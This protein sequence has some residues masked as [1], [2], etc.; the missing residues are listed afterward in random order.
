MPDIKKGQIVFLE[1][2]ANGETRVAIDNDLRG[3]LQGA[4]FQ[5][6]LLKIWLGASR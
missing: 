6:A 1:F 5:R 4:D 2:P 3:T